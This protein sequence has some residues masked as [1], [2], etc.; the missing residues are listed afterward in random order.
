MSGL[1]ILLP[2]SLA[3]AA[4]VA[5]LKAEGYDVRVSDKLVESTDAPFVVSVPAPNYS[6][7]A[8]R[9]AQWK[10]ERRGRGR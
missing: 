5:Q 9:E 6:R 7:P 3:T 8:R 10:R 1:R 2:P 4:V